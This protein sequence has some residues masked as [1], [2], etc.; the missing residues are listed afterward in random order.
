MKIALA[1]YKAAPRRVDLGPKEAITLRAERGTEVRVEHGLVWIT[2][3]GEAASGST[4]GASRSWNTL[5]GVRAPRRLRNSSATPLHGLR[6]RGDASRGGGARQ[7][8]RRG[9]RIRRTRSAVRAP[10][11]QRG[12]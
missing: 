3:A 1:E 2:Q 11:W 12:S 8:S 7:D 6:Q 4:T 5:H 10:W 9:K